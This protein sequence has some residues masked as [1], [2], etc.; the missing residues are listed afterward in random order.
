VVQVLT[1]IHITAIA[2]IPLVAL[3]GAWWHAQRPSNT[4]DWQP[5]VARLATAK[6]QG[7]YVTVTNVRNFRYRSP[8]DF[9]EGW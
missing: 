6:I 2:A 5:D 3:L 4:R 8:T 7:C 1:F 9:D